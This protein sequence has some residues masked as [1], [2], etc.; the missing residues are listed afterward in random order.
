MI[1][2][3]T[4]SFLIECDNTPIKV[5]AIEPNLVRRYMRKLAGQYSTHQWS[6]SERFPLAGAD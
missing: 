3:K 5:M 6:V 1:R 2:S 4:R